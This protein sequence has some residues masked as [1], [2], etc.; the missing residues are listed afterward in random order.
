MKSLNVFL[1]EAFT[2][3]SAR[4]QV[5]TDYTYKECVARLKNEGL[6]FLTITLPELG[7]A[8]ESWLDQ[9]RVDLNPELMRKFKFRE[10]TPNFLGGVLDLVFDRGTGRLLDDPDHTAI[11]AM[12]QITLMFAKINL[13]CSDA[14]ERAAIDQYI[15]CEEEVREQDMRLMCN[16]EMVAQ[17]DRISNL[18]WLPI[19]TEVDRKIYNHEIVPNHGPGATADRLRGNSKWSQQE[20]PTR[21]DDIFPWE[22]MCLPNERSHHW[23]TTDVT[24]L[25]PEAERPVRVV[26]VP[27]TLKTPR[28]IAIE[29]TAMQ[30]VQQGIEDALFEAVEADDIASQLIGY[31]SQVPNQ[32]LA[33]EGSLFGDLATLDM[34][35]ASDRVSNQHVLL[36][37]SRTRH[38]REGVQACRST[39]ADVPGHGIISLSK[40]AS[41][42]SALTFPVEAMVFMTVIFCGIENALNRRL[43]RG[44]I[45]R[46]LGRVRVYGDDIIIPVDMTTHVVEALESFGFRINSSKSFWTGMFR[47]SCGKDYFQGTD[48]SI[49]KL[50]SVLPTKREHASEIIS[51]LETSNLLY[52][53]GMWHSARYLADLVEELIPLP[54]VGDESPMLG[55]VSFMGV[56]SPERIH[57]HLHH[58]LVRGGVVTARTPISRLDGTWALLKCLTNNRR[59]PIPDV[60][61]LERAGRPHAVDIKLRWGPQL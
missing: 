13:K 41:M 6:S 3:V 58:P 4:C 18:L 31:R 47:E 37:M 34:S 59:Q 52:K 32:E 1:R 27:K 28:I 14:R 16:P 12:R 44:L 19:L 54:I 11:W 21:L 9:G 39:K 48:V 36:L 40:F 56:P 29:P 5:S 61:H 22:V 50:R 17:Y 49:V 25:E 60:G 55:L 20:W 24:F 15:Q 51:T 43:T 42:G 33:W 10:A 7:K 38:L 23:E 8:F 45:K 35:E 46:F 30:Y 26:T 2:D 53:A 57:P